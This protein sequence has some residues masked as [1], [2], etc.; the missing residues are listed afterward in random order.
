[1]YRRY[2]KPAG[3]RRRPTH[4]DD[5]IECALIG[6]ITGDRPTCEY[7]RVTALL[8]RMLGEQGQPRAIHKRIYGVMKM[9][10]LLLQKT[11]GKTHRIPRRDNHHS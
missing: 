8:N 9:N 10:H 2:E 3:S 1:M 11:Y 4:P 5:G 7:Q 6:M